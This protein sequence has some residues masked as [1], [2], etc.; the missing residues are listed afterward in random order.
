MI[1]Q[2]SLWHSRVNIHHIISGV[3]DFNTFELDAQSVLWVCRK[4]VDGLQLVDWLVLGLKRVR[5]VNFD[6]SF[7]NRNLDIFAILVSVLCGKRD[8]VGQQF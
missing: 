5:L 6:R 2:T 4:R 1:S 8:D 3:I 7:V